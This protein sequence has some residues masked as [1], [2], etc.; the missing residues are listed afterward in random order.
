[1]RNFLL[2]TFFSLSSFAW[3]AQEWKMVAESTVCDEKIQIMG[4]DGEKYVLAIRGPEKR[5]LFSKDGSAFNENSMQMTEF[6]STGEPTYNF[7]Y[8]S[9]VDG[10]P[11]KIDVTF[12]G[13]KKRCKMEL[14]R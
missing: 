9:Y 6:A 10:N 11:P 4:K 7:I 12:S 1:M 13:N 5:K 2:I 3:A 8:P 14:N